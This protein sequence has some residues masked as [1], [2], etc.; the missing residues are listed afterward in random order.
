MFFLIRAFFW[1]G[2]VFF[3]MPGQRLLGEG[4]NSKSVIGS[5]PSATKLA[6]DVV[7]GCLDRPQACQKNLDAA[8]RIAARMDEGRRIVSALLD[9]PAAPA[10]SIRITA[11]PV[12]VPV[13]LP[14]PKGLGPVITR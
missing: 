8:Q 12:S 6:G 13:P 4:A 2:L 14:R 5:V 1:I 11:V 7:H 3:L 10:E 9:T